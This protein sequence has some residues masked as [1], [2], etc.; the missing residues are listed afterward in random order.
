[1][2]HTLSVLKEPLRKY[3]TRGCCCFCGGGTAA[4]AVPA[5]LHPHAVLLYFVLGG[6]AVV[7]DV[8]SAP[9]MT[10]RLSSLRQ[11]L[12]QPL[13]SCNCCSLLK[14]HSDLCPLLLHLH[15]LPCFGVML[16]YLCNE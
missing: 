13:H 5:M 6:V 9:H 11:T 8:P 15:H 10:C 1:M 12:L 4:A 2:L 3:G 7:A 16:C 14:Y